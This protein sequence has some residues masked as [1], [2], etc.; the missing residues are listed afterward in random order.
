[1]SIDKTCFISIKDVFE[2]GHLVASCRLRWP[3]CGKVTCGSATA[4]QCQCLSWFCPALRVCRSDAV[5]AGRLWWIKSTHSNVK[6]KFRLVFCTT[7]WWNF[8]NLKLLNICLLTG[9][10][11]KIK[12]LFCG[13]KFDHLFQFWHF[14]FSVSIFPALETNCKVFFK[15]EVFSRNHWI[16]KVVSWVFG[17]SRSRASVTGE[18]FT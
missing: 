5:G 16:L 1:M 13:K 7:N 12:V 2:V 10:I 11:R 6:L 4:C 8:C 18:Y 3:K 14:K 9:F 15:K 17:W